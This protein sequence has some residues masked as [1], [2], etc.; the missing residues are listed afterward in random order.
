MNSRSVHAK[1]DATILFQFASA[2][3]LTSSAISSDGRVRS[4]SSS[5][6]TERYVKAGTTVGRVRWKHGPGIV[7]M[8]SGHDDS[9][10]QQ[11]SLL[12]LALVSQVEIDIQ[13]KLGI[14]PGSLRNP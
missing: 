7:Y 2:P 10:S 1:T 3:Q 5:H 6:S 9:T 13:T 11:M 8:E 12:L 14:G 4:P